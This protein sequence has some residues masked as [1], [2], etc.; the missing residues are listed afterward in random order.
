[1]KFTT[2]SFSTGFKT[3][4]YLRETLV[5]S[6]FLHAKKVGFNDNCLVEACKDFGYPSVR[7]L[8]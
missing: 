4:K 5:K 2:R 8:T 1:M 6:A 7:K 3:E